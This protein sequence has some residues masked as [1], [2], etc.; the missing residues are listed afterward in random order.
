MQHI[1]YAHQLELKYRQ[2]AET[3][4]RIEK[5]SLPPLAPVIASPRPYGY[6]GKAEF[7]LAGG[8]RGSRR[9][10]LMA[11]ASPNGSVNRI[12]EVS[13]DHPDSR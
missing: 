9:V 7:H 10:G 3:F 13:G 2:V 1:A 4:R 8:Q 12:P 6:R 5:L 11:L